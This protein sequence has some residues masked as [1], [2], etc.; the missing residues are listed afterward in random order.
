MNCPSCGFHATLMRCPQCH[1]AFDTAISDELEHLAYTRNLL[2]RWQ[3]AGKLDGGATAQYLIDLT[4]SDVLRLRAQIPHADPF[5]IGLPA[6]PRPSAKP[7]K[8]PVAAAKPATSA[9]T[10]VL[11]PT[12]P[13]AP[14]A[15]TIP[16]RPPLTWAQVGAYLLSERTLNTL[17]GLGALL[18]L[19]SAF[20]IS[21]LNPTHLPPYAHLAV[22]F[23]TTLAFYGSGV[24]VRAKLRLTRA[25]AALLVIGAGLIPLTI[26]TLG[27]ERMP[28]WDTGTVWLVASAL[29]LPIYLVSHLLLR[30][31]PFA[32]LAALAG[33]SLVLATA[34]QAGL[35]LTWALVGLSL[36]AVA[37]LLLAHALRDR[38]PTLAWALSWSSM[39]AVPI[40]MLA[41]LDAHLDPAHWYRTVAGEH[42]TPSEYAVGVSWWIGTAFYALC[43]LLLRRRR[44]EFA[45]AWTLP[46]AYFLTL[47]KMPWDGTWYNLCLAVLVF[48]YVGYAYARRQP[49]GARLAV[50]FA[51]QPAYGV[52][53]VLS[54]V[55]ALWP[56]ATADSRIATLLTLS[57]AFAAAAVLL[58][59]CIGA[60]VSVY[61]LPVALQLIL[62]RA[63]VAA[64]SRPLAWLCLAVALLVCAEIA[65]RRNA[66]ADR[67]LLRASFW[68]GPWRSGF[69]PAF[70]TAGYAMSVLAVGW[71]GAQ[72][73]VA[74]RLSGI[75]VPATATLIALGGIVALYG[76]CAV[77]RRSSIFLYAAATLAVPEYEA[78]AAVLAHHGGQMVT[79]GAHVWLLA[80]LGMGYL[81]VAYGV[82]LRWVRFAGPFYLVG[83]ALLAAPMFVLNADRAT[84]VQ[85]GAL[86]LLAFAWSAWLVRH[87]RHPAYTGAVRRLWPAGPASAVTVARCLFVYLDAW[88]FPIW[89]AGTLSLWRPAPGIVT[90]GLALTAL[91]PFYVRAAR[92]FARLADGSDRPWYLGGYALSALG[93]LLALSDSTAR[94]AAL[95][96]SMA[97]YAASA[98]VS[99]RRG[100]LIPVATLIPVLL[101]FVLTRLDVPLRLYG[102]GLLPGVAGS[103]AVAETLR[104]RLDNG[105][106][107]T[108]HLLHSRAWCAP[109]YAVVAMQGCLTVAALAV[110]G[111][112]PAQSGDGLAAAFWTAAA[113]GALALIVAVS[114]QTDLARWGSA[115][116]GAVTIELALR[117]AGVAGEQEPPY[118]AATALLAALASFRLYHAAGERARAWS[119]TL[120]GTARIVGG[121]AFLTALV[122]EAGNQTRVDMQSLSLTLAVTGA[123]VIAYGYF[124]RA[125][126]LSYG[127]IAVLLL[128]YM[129]QLTLYD[130]TQPQAFVLPA[131]IYLLAVAYLEARRGLN[132]HLRATLE[133]CGVIVLLVTSLLQAGGYAT[134]GADRLVYEVFLLFESLAVVGLGATMHWKRSLFGGSAAMIADIGLLLA[135]PLRAMNTW[136]LMAIVGL[137]IITLVV[138]L[139]QRRNEITHWVDDWRTRL[140]SWT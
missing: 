23:A 115:A 57:L 6:T 13:A 97:L 60:Y 11:A 69:A 76:L 110:I 93:P 135:D 125:R 137:T 68:I 103:L 132:A 51:R 8:R 112:V 75:A 109:F 108:R 48:G 105:A 140:E 45:A 62:D 127:G 139:E 79:V 37:Y 18:I 44:Y 36:L 54:L 58:Q 59:E 14:S 41:L 94:I 120:S 116:F 86:N 55:A 78:L 99:R 9:A 4:E 102:L 123:A 43:S 128:S 92:V 96:I 82:A 72:F 89:L 32:A 95:A 19:A 80:L 29:C 106:A 65:A 22:M 30:D 98:A 17:L 134:D 126:L 12:P 24:A 129:L 35:A 85:V 71:T 61:L 130:V 2:D 77:I 88:L 42:S 124:R 133:S 84:M 114:W 138:F 3:R 56:S 101:A 73:S 46:V 70:F 64:P 16:A 136:Y 34:H 7:W 33:G 83:Y 39:L 90:Y 31:R 100:W 66:E 26:W 81:M 74:P 121:L 113:Y 87:G 91:A 50:R 47:T 5:V 20:V 52:V 67:S 38:R 131:G 119:A 107:G 40:I 25:G 27:Q 122:V 111:Y 15:P 63:V 104:R 1:T 53:V 28:Q 118:W 10:T 21:T 49:R 117:L